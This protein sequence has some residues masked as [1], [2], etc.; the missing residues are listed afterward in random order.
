MTGKPWPEEAAAQAKW[1]LAQA[2]WPPALMI[3]AC[4]AHF[5]FA[6][7]RDHGLLDLAVRLLATASG[8]A[9]FAFSTILVFDALLFRLMASYEDEWKG[10]AAVD[11]I[12]AR[13]S[14]KPTPPNTRSLA[15]RA[16][17]TRRV[18]T[19]QRVAFAVLVLALA[20]PLFSTPA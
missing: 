19:R 5:L 10:G 12:L 3:A 20:L 13:M 16:A 9:M 6:Q 7:P 4:G 1:S 17:G 8:I 14:L 2:L 15:E 11:D 18:V